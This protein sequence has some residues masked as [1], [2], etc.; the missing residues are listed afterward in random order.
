MQN[1][2]SLDAAAVEQAI[3]AL[4]RLTLG[5][6]FAAAVETAKR[7]MEELEDATLDA[8]IVGVEPLGSDL[9]ADY[10]FFTADFRTGTYWEQLVVLHSRALETHPR[11]ARLLRSEWVLRRIVDV[12][13][14]AM[15]QEAAEKRETWYTRL[16][17]G[18][19]VGRAEFEPAATL[20]ARR[21]PELQAQL[22]AAVERHESHQRQALA[23]AEQKRRDEEAAV[24]RL[25]REE[26]EELWRYFSARPQRM[27]VIRHGLAVLGD[28]L[29]RQARRE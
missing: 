18:D 7:A 6:P 23:R 13:A 3:A 19:L 11:L 22:A 5:L 2:D 14:I 9:S 20:L 16:F 27:Y 17:A 25:E 21:L 26:R 28:A 8:L 24:E 12:A 10:E 4:D 15:P 1:V 29:A